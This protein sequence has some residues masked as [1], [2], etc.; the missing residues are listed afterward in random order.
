MLWAKQFT[1]AA[2][3][4]GYLPL[5]DG[6]NSATTHGA[7]QF[8]VQNLTDQPVQVSL[9]GGTTDHFPLAANGYYVS[10]ITT[11]QLKSQL[12][13]GPILAKGTII[14]VKRI[15]GVA[16]TGTVYF[17]FWYELGE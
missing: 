3:G 14:S 9:D 6:V 15:G 12:D 1:N 11:N 16:P 5:T 10:D 13:D 4:A 17:S 8:I 2:V 7:R